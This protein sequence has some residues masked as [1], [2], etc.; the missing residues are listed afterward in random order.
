MILRL[1]GT[2]DVTMIMMIIVP[3]NFIEHPVIDPE[4]AGAAKHPAWASHRLR[5]E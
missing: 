3:V 1:P 2:V 5:Q 4:V